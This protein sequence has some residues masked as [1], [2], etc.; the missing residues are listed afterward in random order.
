MVE[1]PHNASPFIFILMYFFSGQSQVKIGNI[2]T[3]GCGISKS[4]LNK[5][6]M[7]FGDRCSSNSTRCTQ[8]ALVVLVPPQRLPTPSWSPRVWRSLLPRLHQEWSLTQFTYLC[9]LFTTDGVF[10]PSKATPGRCLS[11]SAVLQATQE[12]R[13][14]PLKG[15]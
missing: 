9:F 11:F 6:E 15:T 1:D 10:K 12:T 5:R 8:M 13:L 2:F 4:R 3:L 7:Y 14:R